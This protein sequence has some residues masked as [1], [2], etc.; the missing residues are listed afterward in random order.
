MANICFL[1]LWFGKSTKNSSSNLPLRIS[2]GER[3]VV[4]SRDFQND[5]EYS[6]WADMLNSS[7]CYRSFIHFQHQGGYD[8]DRLFHIICRSRYRPV[9][10]FTS[11]V[12]TVHP[13]FIIPVGGNMAIK[14]GI[15]GF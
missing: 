2:S 15:N 12:F 5:R 3:A 10:I 6:P 7:E 9:K 8:V 4:A 11:Q 14:V 1:S 13:V